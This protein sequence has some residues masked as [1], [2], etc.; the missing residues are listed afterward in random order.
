MHGNVNFKSVCWCNHESHQ[1]PS[2]HLKLERSVVEYMN[3]SIGVTCTL[4]QIAVFFTVN[5]LVDYRPNVSRSFLRLHSDSWRQM[6]TWARIERLEVATLPILNGKA[7]P[8]PCLLHAEA[9]Q[10]WGLHAQRHLDPTDLRH[11]SRIT[12][13]SCRKRSKITH[14]HQVPSFR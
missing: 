10:I 11:H 7:L 2:W 3:I 13:C 8:R 5:H 9:H 4:H 6:S 12:Y 14:R 1:Q